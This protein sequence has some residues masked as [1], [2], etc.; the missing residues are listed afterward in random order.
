MKTWN[1]RI[2]EVWEDATGEEV[3]DDTIARVDALAAERGSDDARAEFER[4]GVRATPRGSRPRPWNCTGAPCSSVS[5]RST[6]R[7][8]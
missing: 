8:A 7:S 2:D 6:A 3:G 1:E 5:T 4:A